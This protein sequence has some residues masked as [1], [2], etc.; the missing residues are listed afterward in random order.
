MGLAYLFSSWPAPPWWR[1][2]LHAALARF[3]PGQ[4]PSSA[5]NNLDCGPGGSGHTRRCW[6]L[7]H[8]GLHPAGALRCP[9]EPSGGLSHLPSLG[10]V[11]L[12]EFPRE[13]PAVN[14]MV[15]SPGVSA[16]R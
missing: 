4:G 2:A 16:G 11:L 14:S 10:R 6:R 9:G 1:S 8:L 3:L 15:L 12:P 7:S 5:E 13:V